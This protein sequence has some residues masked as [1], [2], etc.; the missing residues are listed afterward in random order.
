MKLTRYWW[1]DWVQILSHNLDQWLHLLK[2]IKGYMST[3]HHLNCREITF[4]CHKL[5]RDIFIRGYELLRKQCFPG[6]LSLLLGDE[7]WMTV[8]IVHLFRVI[9]CCRTKKHWC[10]WPFATLTV[11]GAHLARAG[12]P[13][14]HIL[15][16]PACPLCGYHHNS[17]DNLPVQPRPLPRTSSKW[18]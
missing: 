8:G 12:F 16:W 2:Q 13:L 15:P 14:I 11:S 5:E 4:Y 1:G 17:Y 7:F 3:L 6:Y 18:L 10:E 9:F